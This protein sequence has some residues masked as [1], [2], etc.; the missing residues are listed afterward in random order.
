MDQS[1]LT[2]ESFASLAKRLGLSLSPSQAKELHEAYR[3]VAAMAERVRG[4]P[5]LTAE[6]AMVFAPGS[7]RQPPC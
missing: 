7:T 1:R 3:N 6:S 4:T 5:S 2:F